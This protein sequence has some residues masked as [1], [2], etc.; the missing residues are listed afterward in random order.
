MNNQFSITLKDKVVLLCAKRNSG[1]SYLLRYLVRRQKHFFDSIFVIC[2]TESINQF[3][4]RDDFINPKN[5][6]TE[7]D[8]EWIDK[9]IKKMTNLNKGKDK[10]SHDFKRVLIILDDAVAD[11]DLH[12]SNTFKI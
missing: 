7:Y 1:K 11:I 9:L 10:T 5:I 12:N 4:S 3:F 2:P 6:M 8:E